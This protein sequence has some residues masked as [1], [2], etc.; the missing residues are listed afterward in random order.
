MACWTYHK[1]VVHGVCPILGRGGVRWGRGGI[2]GSFF[3]VINSEVF[4]VTLLFVS[5]LGKEITSRDTCHVMLLRYVIRKW[6]GSDMSQNCFQL[7]I[8]VPK[9]MCSMHMPWIGTLPY[10]A[11]RGQL[12]RLWKNMHQCIYKHINTQKNLSFSGNYL[13][14][15]KITEF[16]GVMKTLVTF[17]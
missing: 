2:Y 11:N 5:S 13:M 1:V 8:Q 10:F 3:T 9:I 15:L 17:E 12:H 4:V 16:L 6:A 7:V 14:E